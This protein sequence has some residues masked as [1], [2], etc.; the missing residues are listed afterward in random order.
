MK[1]DNDILT[2]E[3]ENTAPENKVITITF[4]I[5]NRTINNPRQAY[6][7][8]RRRTANKKRLNVRS[9]KRLLS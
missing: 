9:I 2:F 6:L 5:S 8:N 4:F 7:K 3:I 1:K